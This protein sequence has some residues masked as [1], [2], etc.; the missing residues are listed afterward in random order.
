MEPKFKRKA[1]LDEWISISASP[2]RLKLRQAPSPLSFVL[3]PIPGTPYTFTNFVLGFRCEATEREM[4]L[5]ATNNL[6]D[7]TFFSNPSQSTP[8]TFAEVLGPE[9]IP[10][11]NPSQM[12]LLQA[13]ARVRQA[14]AA[15]THFFESLNDGD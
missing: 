2:L 11:V 4:E 8:I 7:Q 5:I 6:F 13:E 15:W 10:E 1:F 12:V 9:W 14:A 3:P